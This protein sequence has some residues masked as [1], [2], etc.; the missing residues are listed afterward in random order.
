MSVGQPLYHGTDGIFHISVIIGKRV[1]TIVN[2]VQGVYTD[3][4]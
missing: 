3:D 4:F 2:G 1:Y